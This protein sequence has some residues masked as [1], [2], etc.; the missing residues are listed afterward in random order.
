MSDTRNHRVDDL[1]RLV[2]E[3]HQ[4]AP[5]DRRRSPATRRTSPTGFGRFASRTAATCSSWPA[6]LR[7]LA[8]RARCRDSA[9]EPLSGEDIES[10]VSPVVP[11]R[12]RDRYRDGEAIDL[13][14]TLE[15]PR[16]LSHEPAPRARTP[17]GGD[18]CVADAHSARLGPAFLARHHAARRTAARPRPRL[19]TDRLRQ[20][21]DARGTHRRDQQHAT[22][23]TSSP[24]KTRSSTS[25]RTVEA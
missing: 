17:G 8:S 9:G 10:A 20:D 7:W 24:S 12:L 15:G 11:S 19:W 18:S 25:T 3:L 6:C 4:I 2:S 16:A 13:A 23:G 1:D 22:R 14:F 5:A 21:D